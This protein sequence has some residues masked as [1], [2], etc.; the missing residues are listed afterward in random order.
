[1]HGLAL[2]VLG[3]VFSCDA[4]DQAKDIALSS[5]AIEL[6]RGVTEIQSR[7]FRIPF[8]IDP[9]RVLKTDHVSLYVSEDRGKTWKRLQDRKPRDN[10]F[11]FVAPKDGLYWF[12][13]QIV[14][15]DGKAEPPAP[16]DFVPSLKV[17]VNTAQEDK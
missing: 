12:A 2:M 13:V 14:L 3:I 5:D 8:R 9:A 1:M 17:N 6:E 15:Q 10:E 11:T 4:T 7:G 16:D